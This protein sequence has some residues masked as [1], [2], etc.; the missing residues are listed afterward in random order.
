MVDGGEVVGVEFADAR[1]A[2][3]FVT[4]TLGVGLGLFFKKVLAVEQIGL[5]K[6]KLRVS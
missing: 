4:P 6:F 3:L 1:H 5:P 2:K